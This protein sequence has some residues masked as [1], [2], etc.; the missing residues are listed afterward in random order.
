MARYTNLD[1]CDRKGF[2]KAVG[3]KEF[4][5][6][7]ETAFDMLMALPPAN[8]VEREKIEK[9]IEEIEKL[10]TMIQAYHNDNPLISQAEVLEILDK[11][12]EGGVRNDRE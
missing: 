11:M 10:D 12:I 4:L 6:T 1:D 9:A 8:V 2:Y 5:I 7:A 3:G